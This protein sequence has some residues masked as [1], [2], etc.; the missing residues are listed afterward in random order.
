MGSNGD[1][2]TC[3]ST[4]QNMGMGG[5]LL[6][7]SRFSSCVDELKGNGYREIEAIGSIGISLY[8]TNAEG[9]KIMKVY[10]NSPAAKSGIVRGDVITAINGK[11]VIQNGDFADVHGDIGSPVDI[12][13]KRN[14]KEIDF[15]LVKSKFTYSRFLSD[16][17]Y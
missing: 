3:A 10:D 2:K 7:N 13:I 4:S 17:V 9:L 11:K 8:S 16:V 15:K 14:D 5:V 1:I 12:T 6:A